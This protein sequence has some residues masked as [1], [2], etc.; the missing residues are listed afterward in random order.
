MVIAKP[1]LKLTQ[2][3]IMLIC[4]Q[5]LFLELLLYQLVLQNYGTSIKHHDDI[6][7]KDHKNVL[8]ERKSAHR[9]TLLITV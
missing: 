6:H 5:N 8:A 1:V 3:L 2:K 7:V 9:Q 4:R